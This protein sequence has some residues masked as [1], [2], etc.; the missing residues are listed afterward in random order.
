LAAYQ[1]SPGALQTIS[2]C[3]DGK[4]MGVAFE[5]PPGCSE[6]PLFPT[7]CG[8]GAWEASCC[9]A[10]F[11]FPQEGYQALA[12]ALA[13]R[14]AVAGLGLPGAVV[15]PRGTLVT[16]EPDAQRK[17]R[18]KEQMDKLAQADGVRQGVRAAYDPDTQSRN[19]LK[20]QLEQ[21][22]Q[23]S[24]IPVDGIVPGKHV[25]LHVHSG[26]WQGWYACEVVDTDPQGCYVRHESDGYT[27]N[28]P[29]AFLNSGK[30][31]MELLHDSLEIGEEN[32]TMKDVAPP[33]PA[34][35][36]VAEAKPEL[37]SSE[38]DF[39]HFGRLRVHSELGAGLSL[40]LCEVGYF[41]TKIHEPGQPDLKKGDAIV[42]IGKTVLLGLEG[43]ELE[44][45]FG[46]EFRDSAAIVAGH[47]LSLRQLSFKDMRQEA[48]RILNEPY[49]IHPK[50]A[51]SGEGGGGYDNATV[52]T[53]QTM[54][55]PKMTRSLSTRSNS[56]ASFLKRG[57]LNLDQRADCPA[58]AGLVLSPCQAGYLVEEILPL[59]G[60][61]DLDIGDAIVAIG[62]SLLLGLTEDELEERFGD[63]YCDGAALIAGPH[64]ELMA[65]PFDIVMREVNLLLNSSSEG[66]SRLLTERARTY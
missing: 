35:S 27:E 30:Y 33:G 45:R 1:Y 51:S 23:A 6:V 14:D 22:A 32:I 54:S 17:N 24:C 21:L 52:D 59:P 2:F 64:S 15:A 20:E 16:R 60:Q 18:L 57:R 65:W 31:S 41:V 61:R 46:D 38:S 7:V 48:E 36:S 49:P 39:L 29:W 37:K 42:A 28:I 3:L 26:P 56:G 40:N 66:S 19:R 62:H 25:V 34:V 53:S 50:L 11:A 44:K 10:D 55:A 63:A 4:D 12:G 8:K 5:I 9:Y 13:A 43:D 58:G 47:Y